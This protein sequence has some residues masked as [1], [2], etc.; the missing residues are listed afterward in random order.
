[1]FI[2]SLLTRKGGCA[3]NGNKYYDTSAVVQ[4]LGSIFKDSSFLD[5]KGKYFLT[6]Q[7][8]APQDFH[9]VV[10]GAAADLYSNGARNITVTDI[11]DYLKD[12]R[13]NSWSVYQACGG[14]KWVASA[15]DAAHPE[16]FKFY[17]DRVKKFTLLRN[18]TNA[19]MD[20]T[21][22]YDPDNLIDP[23]KRQQQL[24]ELDSTPLAK[25]AEKVEF[26]IS[27]VRQD[28][29]TVVDKTAVKAG[30]SIDALLDGLRD[31]PETGMPFSY[32]WEEDGH[33]ELMNQV[34]LGARLG[35]FFLRSAASGVGKSRSLAADACMLACK[36][37][38]QNNQWIDLVKNPENSK[39][40]GV[41]FISTELNV[42][43]LQTLF[44]SFIS[45]VNEEKIL[46]HEITP[47]ENERI[48][49][50]AEELKEAP[51]YIELLPNFTVSDVENVIIRNHTDPNYGCNY[52]FYD[53]LGTSL[54]ILE[55]V[56]GRA[57]GVS[58]REDSILFLL[59]TRLKELAVQYNIFIES[60]TQLNAS[61][62]TDMIPD[63]NLLRGS[64]AVADRIDLGTILLNVT[65]E[66]IANIRR[67][68]YVENE[69][70]GV[71]P[72]VKLSVY[73]NRR[74]KY[75]NCYIWMYADKGTCRFIPLGATTWD[76]EPYE[77]PRLHLDAMAIPDQVG[78]K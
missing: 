4:I 76:L 70:M 22:V 55:E 19:G 36:H 3:I 57:R 59:A 45:G 17:Y 74:G 62:K 68:G 1:M 21:W 42:S 66:D 43:E 5:Q 25:I 20:V 15:I 78:D 7:D 30:D 46:T 54:G 13:P 33:S 63:Q 9:R 64:K 69:F 37:I 73:K 39:R 8:F 16:N 10:Y 65:P 67:A 2:I 51:L 72:N 24:D 27:S 49:L 29:V 75:V 14:A 40:R 35:K 53:Y 58:M 12:G 32:G 61:W 60:A 38:W 31:R 71:E 34:G 50:A 23:K 28:S 77:I 26:R 41:L 18:Y 52:F 6:A 47:E 11:E 48:R 44:V 56:A